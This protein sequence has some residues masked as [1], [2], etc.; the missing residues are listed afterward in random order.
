M[1]KRAPATIAG[2]ASILGFDDFGGLD[3]HGKIPKT[4]DGRDHTS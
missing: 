4:Q 2:D 1:A 3:G